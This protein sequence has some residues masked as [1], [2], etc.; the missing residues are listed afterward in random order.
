MMHR[1]HICNV[2]RP[3]LAVAGLNDCGWDVYFT[4]E[5]AWME[6]RES[7]VIVSFKRIG[8]RFEFGAKVTGAPS[9]GTG[10]HLA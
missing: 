7:G 6:H 9:G 4:L 8:G 3:L 10:P 5:G 2:R 1:P